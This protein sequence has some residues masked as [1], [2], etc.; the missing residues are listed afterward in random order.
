MTW[1]DS[2]R[3]EANGYKVLVNAE[4][5]YALWPADKATPEGW[6]DAGAG[7]DKDTCLTYIREVWTDMRPLSLRR[8]MEETA[9]APPAPSTSADEPEPPG[10][11]E[12][13]SEGEHPVEVDLR[14]E[15]T[16]ALLR[17][18]I[19]RDYVSIRFTATRGAA[20]FGFKLDEGA[21]DFS[22]ADFDEGVGTVH[23][24]GGLTV[25]YH[26]VRCVAD[27]DLQSLQGRGRLVRV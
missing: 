8:R 5:Q 14:P 15:K 2:E 22:R 10:L 24:E 6:R 21:C 27:I 11:V 13:L 26:P 7:G 12:R 17:Q 25:D 20:E 1:K 18:A 3:E 16:A 23:L 4:E 19:A 9:Q